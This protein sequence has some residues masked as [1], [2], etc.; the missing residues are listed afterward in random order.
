MTVKELIEKLKDCNPDL[1]VRIE[2]GNY[3]SKEYNVIHFVT[4]SELEESVILSND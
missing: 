4:E 3:E 1:I 2:F